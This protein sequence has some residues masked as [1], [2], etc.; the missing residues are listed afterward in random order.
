VISYTLGFPTNN[1]YTFLIASSRATCSAHLLLDLFTLIILG[2]EYKSRSS[3]L[4]S[5]HHPPNTSSLFGPNV[6]L[7]TLFSNTLSQCFSL[8]VRNQVS[9]PYRTTGKTIVLYILISMFFDSRWENKILHWLLASITRIQF[10]LNFFLNQILIC[11]CRPQIFE[12]WH[13][14]IL[15]VCYFYVPILSCILVTRQ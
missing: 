5:F 14:F 4:C 8:N 7:S 6:L 12:L 2:E 3:S 11:Y 13:I 15:C 9:R 10:P 1:L